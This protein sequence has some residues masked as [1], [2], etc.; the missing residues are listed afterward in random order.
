MPKDYKAF[1]DEELLN[2]EDAN[3]AQMSRYGRIMQHRANEAAHQLAKQLNGV[4]VTLYRASEGAQEK[5]AALLAKID[6]G[7]ARADAAIAAAQTAAVEQRRQQH[8]VTFLTWVLVGCTAVYTM[9]NGVSTYQANQGNQIQG[10]IEADAREQLVVSR[11][12]SA[13]QRAALHPPPAQTPP[14]GQP[15]QIQR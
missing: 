7:I 4:T 8:T 2:Y 13:L 5:A 12:A 14:P 6:E 15:K 3:T 11:E 10:R 1:S 9:I